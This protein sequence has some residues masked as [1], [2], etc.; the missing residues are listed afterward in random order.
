MRRS[1]AGSYSVSDGNGGTDTATLTFSFA[2]DASD[3]YTY[4]FGAGHQVVNG[5]QH[6]AGNEDT[7]LP[8]RATTP[9][10]AALALTISTGRPATTC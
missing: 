3:D 9:S 10:M 5:D 2:P 4:R 1:F 6:G 8:A 7:I